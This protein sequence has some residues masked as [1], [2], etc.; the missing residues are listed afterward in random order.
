MFG[1]ELRQ[2]VDIFVDNHPEIVRFLVCGYIALG[3][4]FGHGGIQYG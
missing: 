2:V 4:Y 3:K 1:L